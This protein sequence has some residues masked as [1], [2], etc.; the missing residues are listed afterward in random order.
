MVPI[1]GEPSDNDQSKTKAAEDTRQ[2]TEAPATDTTLPTPVS[3]AQEGEL[4][5]TESQESITETPEEQK[6]ESG[7]ILDEKPEEE[8]KSEENRGDNR[9]SLPEVES[10]TDSIKTGTQS[11]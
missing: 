8:R 2:E 5:Q 3:D 9:R 10:E 11:F 7:E 1:K 6:M 4:S